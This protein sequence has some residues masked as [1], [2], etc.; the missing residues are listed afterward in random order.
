MIYDERLANLPEAIW[1]ANEILQTVPGDRDTL[2]RLEALLERSGDVRQLVQALEQHTKYA[3]NPD[4]KIQL[5]A[6]GRRA[7]S[8]Q[9]R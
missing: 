9:A 2:T 8:E 4:E 3:A 7:G 5:P 1:A 6:P